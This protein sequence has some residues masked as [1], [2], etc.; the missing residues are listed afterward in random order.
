MSRVTVAALNILGAIVSS[1]KLLQL[2]V[3]VCA[4]NSRD[5][6]IMP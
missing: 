5:S 4:I 3:I 6:A 2:V 1:N